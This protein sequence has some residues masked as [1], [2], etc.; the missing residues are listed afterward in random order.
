MSLISSGTGP[1]DVVPEMVS[2]FLQEA[3]ATVKARMVNIDF[4]TIDCFQD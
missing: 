1:D 2:S 3:K 4:F